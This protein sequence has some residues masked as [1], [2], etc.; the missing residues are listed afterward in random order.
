MLA[1]LVS[2]VG[3]V[4]L[5][6]FDNAAYHSV[7]DENNNPQQRWP[8]PRLQSW[9]EAKGIPFP[10]DALKGEIWTIARAYAIENPRYKVDDKIRAAGLEVLRLPPY[11]CEIN[12][13]EKI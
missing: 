13:I 2:Q 5:Q 12:A 4:F 7:K 6:V 11:H 9:L 10:T 3:F 8:K 1:T